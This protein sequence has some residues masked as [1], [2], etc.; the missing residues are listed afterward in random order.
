MISWPSHTLP[1]GS[2]NGLLSSCLHT[3]PMLASEAKRPLVLL[4]KHP[5]RCSGRLSNDN[6]SAAGRW[7]RFTLCRPY[8]TEPMS[9]QRRSEVSHALLQ[10][11]TVVSLPPLSFPA[12]VCCSRI[13][14]V[15]HIGYAHTILLH[16]QKETCAPH[17]KYRWY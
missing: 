14:N 17:L 10:L 6:T 13:C 16:L 9:L 12:C 3:L 5:L 2:L 11:S 1:G 15:T 4:K 7:T 8:L